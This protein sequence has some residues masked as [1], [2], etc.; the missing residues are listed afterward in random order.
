MTKWTE[1]RTYRIEAKHI[2]GLIRN[3]HFFGIINIIDGEH[4]LSDVVVFARIGA[5]QTF[6]CKQPN[7]L[8]VFLDL[9]IELTVNLRESVGAHLVED[10]VVAFS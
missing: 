10:V 3:S 7:A 9:P 2:E 4:A 1:S 6:L 8:P 5:D